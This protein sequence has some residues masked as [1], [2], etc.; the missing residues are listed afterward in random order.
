MP[1]LIFLEYCKKIQ[2]RFKNRIILVKN[3]HIINLI[4]FQEVFSQNLHTSNSI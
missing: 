3:L 4:K 1:K 2:I